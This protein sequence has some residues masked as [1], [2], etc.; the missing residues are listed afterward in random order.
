M[1]GDS[2]DIQ[3]KILSLLPKGWL[4]D[5]APNAAAVFGGISD[6]F[7]WIYSFYTAVLAQ[8]RI[9][10]ATSWVLD[11]IAFDFF[12]LNFLRRSGETDASF[13]P[14]IVPEIFRERVT[15]KGIND[16]LVNLTGRAPKIFEPWNT[17]DCGVIGTIGIGVAGCIGSTN[18]P[19]QVFITAYRPPGAGIPNV[20]GIGSGY[21]GYTPII[22]DSQIQSQ[23]SDAEIYA[24]IADTVAAGVTAWV[25]IQ[26]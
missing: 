11:L 6:A 2:N 15:R 16:A 5:A 13:G 25:A 7:A 10:T 8:M 12:G 18:L 14:R 23:V 1:I 4:A 22:N 17:G 26:N 21:I 24:T 9:S 20:Q 19:Y 3:S